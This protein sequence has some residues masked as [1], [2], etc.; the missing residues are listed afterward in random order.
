MP[1]KWIKS[2]PLIC[3]LCSCSNSP[4]GWWPALL[5]GQAAGPSSACCQ[6]RPSWPF[7]QSCPQAVGPQPLKLQGAIPSQVQDLVIVLAQFSEVPVG[8]S[9]SLLWSLRVTALPLSIST[10]PP[11]LVCLVSNHSPQSLS[12]AQCLF[13]SGCCIASALEIL[14][15]KLQHL[16]DTVKQ[17][18]GIFRSVLKTLRISMKWEFSTCL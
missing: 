1:S 4:D 12:S 3:W 17:T 11:S 13:A 15:V 9:C 2:L 16:H 7:L 6:P 5:L 8:L 18:A 10:H 14:V